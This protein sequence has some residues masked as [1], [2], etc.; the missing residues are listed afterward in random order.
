ML[1]KSA[2]LFLIWATTNGAAF[3]LGANWQSLFYFNDDKTVARNVLA[4][5]KKVF[6]DSDGRPDYF[7]TRQIDCVRFLPR[8]GV[9]GAIAIYCKNRYTGKITKEIY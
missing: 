4:D 6:P 3:W 9:Y 7:A 1:T 8:F 5:A 2:K